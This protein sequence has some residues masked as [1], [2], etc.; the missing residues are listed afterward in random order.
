MACMNSITA[1]GCMIVQS[2][3]NEL[4]VVYTSAYSACNKYINPFMLPSVTA[5]FPYRHLQVRITV[6]KNMTALSQ[7]F[8][9][10]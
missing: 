6:Q 7:V 1:V 5:S 10:V 4:G 2:Y 9:L 8:G 3:V